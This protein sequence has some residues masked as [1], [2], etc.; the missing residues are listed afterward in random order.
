MR[1]LSQRHASSTA[2][3][4]R[5]TRPSTTAAGTR[6]NRLRREGGEATQQINDHTE[7]IMPAKPLEQ[8]TLVVFTDRTG[9]EY[10][11][12]LPRVG[13]TDL[14]V[15]AVA[16]R[17]ACREIAMGHWKPVG[18]LRYRSIGGAL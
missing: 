1:R 3:H 7:A 12:A 17:W 8:D 16:Y 11:V 13:H 15:R 10:P 9:T 4:T 14:E 2:K 18:E 5:A 6:H